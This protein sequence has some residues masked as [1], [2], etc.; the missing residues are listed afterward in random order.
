VLPRYQEQAAVVLSGY[1]ATLNPSD[2]AILYFLQ[3]CGE[4]DVDLAEFKP[5]VFGKEAIRHYT[6]KVTKTGVM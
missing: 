4:N 6:S 2:R 5:I 1:S 3:L